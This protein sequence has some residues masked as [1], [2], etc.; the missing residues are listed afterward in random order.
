MPAHGGGGDGLRACSHAGRQGRSPARSRPWRCSHVCLSAT[1]HA[2]ALGCGDARLRFVLVVCSKRGSIA[3]CW[4]QQGPTSVSA[5]RKH[6]FSWQWDAG[7]QVENLCV[8]HLRQLQAA[9]NLQRCFSFIFY[10][11]VCLYSKV[12]RS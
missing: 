6:A 4:Q 12:E 10:V 5:K 11:Y 7:A 8:W 9:I 1:A 2:C 3:R